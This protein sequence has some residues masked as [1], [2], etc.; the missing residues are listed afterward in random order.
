[1]KVYV[2]KNDKGQYQ[3][4]DM[5]F[6]YSIWLAD[7]FDDYEVAKFYCG[8]DCNVV[9]CELIEKSELADHDKKV[10]AEVVAENQALKERW[11]KLIEYIDKSIESD[12]KYLK[13]F[14]NNMNFENYRTAKRVILETMKELEE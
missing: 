3:T 8:S 13:S 5:D 6:I 7:I 12:N 4:P 11:G 9:E 14:P 10:R 1:M 2:I